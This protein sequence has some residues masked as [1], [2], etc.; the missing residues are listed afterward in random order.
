MVFVGTCE[1]E[2]AHY[3]KSHDWTINLLAYNNSSSCYDQGILEDGPVISGK[4]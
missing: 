4:Y 2:I 1:I 3:I